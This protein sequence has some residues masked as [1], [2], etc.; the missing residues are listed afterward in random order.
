[1]TQQELLEALRDSIQEQLRMVDPSD[2]YV[3]QESE[4]E[5]IYALRVEGIHTLLPG[6]TIEEA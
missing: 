2:I 6:E 4:G 3:L 1:M 5:T